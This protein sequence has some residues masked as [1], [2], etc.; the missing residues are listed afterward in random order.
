MEEPTGITAIAAPNASMIPALQ[1]ET[2]A[3]G[4]TA[5]KIPSIAALTMTGARRTNLRKSVKQPYERTALDQVAE[6]GGETSFQSAEQDEDPEV[7][8]GEVDAD[9]EAAE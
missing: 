7:E 1:L 6:V 5:N 8:D 9:E 4:E 2:G 3:G